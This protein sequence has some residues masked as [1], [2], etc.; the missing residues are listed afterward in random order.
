MLEGADH[1]WSVPTNLR[2]G[3]RRLFDD[4]LWHQSR[5][6][7]DVESADPAGLGLATLGGNLAKWAVTVCD[8]LAMIHD[9]DD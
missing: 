7:C 2:P 4:R 6:E 9:S 8:R 1:D 3:A 5:Y